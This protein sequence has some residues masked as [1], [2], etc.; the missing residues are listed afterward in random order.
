MLN[1]Y[2]SDQHSTVL[3]VLLHQHGRHHLR[4]GQRRQGQSW[5]QQAGARL[6]VGGG[7]TEG[8]RPGRPCK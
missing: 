6:H 7:G 8:R 3:A 4:G 1:T 5:H 2:R